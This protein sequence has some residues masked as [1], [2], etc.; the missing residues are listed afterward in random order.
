MK[1]SIFSLRALALM[2]VAAV[3]FGAQA[4]GVD[5]PALVAQYPH[6]ALGLGGMA[7]LGELDGT[8][9]MKALDGV[10]AKLK[11]IAEKADG[12]AK[13]MGKVSDDTKTALENIGIEQKALADRLLQM[14]QKGTAPSQEQKQDASWGAQVVKADSYAAFREGRT[15]KARIEV[16]NTLTG[17]DA[18]VAPDRRPGIIPGA[19]Q[20]L[21]IESLLGSVP[22]TSNSIE[23]TR[24]DT[25]TNN[26]AETAEAAAKP[27]SGLTFSLI[28]QAVSTVA[29]WIKISRQLADDNAALAAYVNNRMIYGVNR[30]VETQLVSGLGTGALISG[31]MKTGN[32]TLHGYLSGGLGSTLPKLVLIRKV[33]ADLWTAG[34][35]AD[36]ILL[37]PGDWAQIEIELF[38]TTSN[39]VRVSVDANGVTRLFGV[40]VVQSVG[41]AA[42]TFLIAN[43]SQAY[44]L[45]TRQGAVVELSESDGDNFTKNLIT[46]RAE[47]RLALATEIPAAARGGDLTP[48]AS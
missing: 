5:I 31:M 20:I 36:A 38:T 41:V 26:A 11:D 33:L 28:T 40:P 35:P 32:Y 16:K 9:I 21:T 29:H 43:F 23:Y 25:F 46:V 22:T 18:T 10:E 19:S 14:E 47:R 13:T 39:T 42:D 37:S 15:Q 45:Y 8:S 48:P 44:T 12:Q 27:E 4:A 7:M 24:E 1:K 6:L 17:N 3:G 30:K 34:Y 2:A